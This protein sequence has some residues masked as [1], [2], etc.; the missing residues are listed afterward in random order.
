MGALGVSKLNC[1]RLLKTVFILV[2]IATFSAAV[3]A[4]KVEGYGDFVATIFLVSLALLAL[5]YCLYA[6]NKGEIE[7]K[8]FVSK[9]SELPGY[10]WFGM[11]IYLS[12]SVAILSIIFV[13][14]E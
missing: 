10:Y 2:C 3:F 1:S 13:Q 4:P 6:F 8:G 12:F 5:T 7:V 9:R 11:L 14:L